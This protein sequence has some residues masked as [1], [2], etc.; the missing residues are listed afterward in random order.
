MAPI[1]AP[2]AGVYGRHHLVGVAGGLGLPTPMYLRLL[3]ALKLKR[4]GLTV[5][6]M[7]FGNLMQF[8][9]ACNMFAGPI[10]SQEYMALVW[11]KKRTIAF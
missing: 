11:R 9:D 10:S 1:G 4:P 7:F 8:Q 3:D 5:A 6:V 2:I